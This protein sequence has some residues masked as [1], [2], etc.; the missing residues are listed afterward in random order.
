M[1]EPLFPI[2]EAIQ[3]VF[4]V[5]FLTLQEAQLV[6]LRFMSMRQGKT[7]MRDYVQMARHLASCITT[8]PMEM[9]TQGNV[10]VDGMRER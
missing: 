3:D 7:N 9:Y 1:E 4:R 10:F 2:L 6:R 8:H 5:A